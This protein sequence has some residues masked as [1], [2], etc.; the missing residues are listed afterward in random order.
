MIILSVR[1]PGF[2]SNVSVLSKP[3]KEIG[4]VIFDFYIVPYYTILSRAKLLSCGV[5]PLRV[6]ACYIMQHIQ[7][8]SC[9]YY[10]IPQHD[11]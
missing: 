9:Q 8:K 10:K 7:I 2:T 3:V 5:F 11:W 1:S 6:V 4:S